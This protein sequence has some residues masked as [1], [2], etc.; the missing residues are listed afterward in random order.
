MKTRSSH[1]TYM[2]YSVQ[3]VNLWAMSKEPVRIL[4]CLF[5]AEMLKAPVLICDKA[6]GRRPIHPSRCM[7]PFESDGS[8]LSLLTRQQHL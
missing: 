5:S 6:E 3:Y 7:H 1:T 4:D 8:S 2:R